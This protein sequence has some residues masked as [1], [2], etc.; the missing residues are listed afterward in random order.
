MDG[1]GASI[2]DSSAS[3][4]LRAA[5]PRSATQ[6]MRVA[7]RPARRHRRQL[8][9][10]A[11]RLVRLH[12]RRPSTT[13][14][15]TCRAGQTDFPLRHFSI[16]H[17]QAQIL[18]LLRQAK[19]LNPALKVMAT[20]WSPPAWMKTSD[21]LVGGRL[22]DDPAIY[23]AYARYLVKF[24]Q[25]YARGRRADRLP[26]RAERAA[27]PHAGRAT[28]APTCR[29]R[30][31]RRS[32]QALG[33]LLQAGQPADQDPRLR[34]QLG[35]A[36]QR[37]RQHPA[38]RGPRDRLPV[39]A[40]R[41]PGREVDRRH[42][43]PLLLRRPERADRAARRV[44]DKGIWFTECSGSHGPTDTPAQIFRDTLDL[45]RPHDRHRHHPQLGAS[46]WSTGTSR[47][48]EDRRPA[49]GRLRHLHRPGHRQPTTARSRTDAEYYT[50]GHLSK[51][52]RPGRGPHRQHR[53]S[54]PP[55]GTAR[56]WTSRSATR[57]APPRWSCT[58]RTTTR[59]AFAVAVGDR[60]FEYTLPGGALA[61]FT[62]PASRALRDVPRQLDL[63]GR[64]GDRVARR[65][66]RRPRRRRRRLDPLVQR[67]RRRRPVST[68]Q[69]DLGRPTTVPAGR[70]RQRRQPRRLRPGLAASRSAPTARRWRTRRRR[71]G[72]RPADQRRRPADPRPVPADHLDGD[73]RQLVEPRRHPPVPLT[74][75]ARTEEPCAPPG[76]QDARST[77]ERSSR[78]PCLPGP[79]P[80][81][82]HVVAVA[83][84]GDAVDGRR[85]PREAVGRRGDRLGHDARA[86][87][88]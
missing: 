87:S 44:P 26:H 19:Q 30:S 68:L 63:C 79:C 31:R 45:A 70:D 13:P 81:P 43:V 12:R 66:R 18:P 71:A 73:R 39:P 36:P 55:A 60:S 23:D 42:R 24:V 10:P 16:A 58:T 57:T 88:G 47:C 38:R 29:S 27:E 86:P 51:F 53:R 11:R 67:R 37:R 65:G 46:R 78:S 56:S 4:A 28:R 62:W 6:A 85:V 41:R 15:T 80:W 75:V 5:R 32:S 17:D 83:G 1:F 77:G 59:A 69:V 25:A 72:D 52:V 14:T 8:P 61:T 48:D 76:R 84:A 2:T 33:P 34:P 54:A 35:D 82:G 21:S 3:A 64:D 49:P 9:A 7:V 74:V 40:A 22:K 20:P 50:I